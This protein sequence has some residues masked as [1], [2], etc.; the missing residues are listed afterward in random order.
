M[1]RTIVSKD[2]NV[3]LVMIVDQTIKYFYYTSYIGEIDHYSLRKINDMTHIVKTK[4]ALIVKSKPNSHLF[5]ECKI[6]F[7]IL[8]K[9]M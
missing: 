5:E 1:L 8:K 7:E 2:N 6:A 4:T 9:F 3:Y